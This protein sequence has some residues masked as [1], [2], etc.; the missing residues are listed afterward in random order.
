M[1][2]L[3]YIAVMV[4][5]VCSLTGRAQDYSRLSERDIMGTSRYVGMSGAM[6]AVGGDPSAVADNPAGLGV[7]LR[8]EA[9][10]TMDFQSDHAWTDD[11]RS[12][13]RLFMVPQASFVF[14]Y[15]NPYED[16]GVIANNFMISYQR[17]KTFH[18]TIETGQQPGETSLGS[19]IASTGVDLK[20]DYP[21]YRT[22]ISNEISLKESGYVN[23]YAL[24][25]GMNISHKFYLGA[26][27]R[28]Y[29]YRL[30]SDA[31]YYERFDAYNEQGKQF[32]L[33]N[34]NS[35][36]MHGVGFG[37]SFGVIYRPC[38]W[39][40]LGA[41]FQTPTVNTLN[42]HTQGTLSAQTD[43]LRYSDAPNMSW[44]VTERDEDSYTAPWHAS[45]GAALQVGDYGM[46]S[47]Q[48]DLT[49]ARYMDNIHTLKAGLEFV[50]VV[51]LYINAGYAY[52]STFKKGDPA[53]V[54]I[55]PTLERQD[56]HSLFP[57]RTQYVSAGIGYRGRF[58]VAQM[59]YQY[60]WQRLQLYAHQAA[61]PYDINTDTHRIVFTIGWHN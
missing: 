55:D 44:R 7:Y 20:M 21:Q 42:T 57:R 28:L 23:Q 32:D 49:H 47:L 14:S 61:S 38:G 5:G 52:S 27:M 26:G 41:S 4:L 50:P 29:S 25:W 45:F 59:A 56:A 9:M 22:N 58:V 24:D 6:T 37:G 11:A 19:V 40:R 34:E 12:T 18:R 31:D 15:G 43:S 54:L 13:R 3:R 36:L 17:L 35:V 1:K 2:T 46:L 60:R 39:V 30:S 53:P 51:G 48:Y 8:S 10:L 16:E 33:E